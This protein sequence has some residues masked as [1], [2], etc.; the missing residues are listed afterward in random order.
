[1]WCLTTKAGCG[2][3]QKCHNFIIIYKVGVQPRVSDI[4][5]V[6]E[7][8]KLIWCPWEQDRGAINKVL[9]NI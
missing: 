1:M 7:T 6:M 9:L 2:G 3:K 5:K 8:I 4:Q